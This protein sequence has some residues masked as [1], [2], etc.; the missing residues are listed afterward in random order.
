MSDQNKK[1]LAIISLVLGLVSLLVPVGII[2]AL[3]GI[4]TGHMARSRAI[5][6]PHQYSGSRTAMLGLIL[7]YTSVGLLVLL[8]ATAN[9]LQKNG[10]LVPLLDTIDESSKLSTYTLAVLEVMPFTDTASK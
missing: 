10:D 2:A 7:S 3:P 1:N 5:H 6:Y 8:I 9:H 4:I